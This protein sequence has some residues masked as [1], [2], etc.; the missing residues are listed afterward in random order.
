MKTG[1]DIARA[2]V[3]LQEEV[4]TLR[5]IVAKAREL[6]KAQR[7]YMADRGNEV[8]GRAVGDAALVFDAACLAAFPRAVAGDLPTIDACPVC[9]S[10]YAA[11]DRNDRGEV[12]VVCRNCGTAGR[13]YLA[14]DEAEAIV[15]WNTLSADS[16]IPV[17]TRR[18]RR[19]SLA[20]KVKR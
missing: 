18:G 4:D 13:L 19:D 10:T 15:D 3:S 8:L 5:D 2:A 1:H 11:V 12:R 20:V 16:R 9:E 14:G 7:A 17:F 6:R